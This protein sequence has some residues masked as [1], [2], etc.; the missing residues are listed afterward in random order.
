MSFNSANQ[1]LNNSG[2]LLKYLEQ[3]KGN[4]K[5]TFSIL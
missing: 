1:S 3:I 5:N 2:A 4:F